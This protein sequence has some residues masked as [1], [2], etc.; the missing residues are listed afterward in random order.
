[1]NNIILSQNQTMS[2]LEMAE[3]TGKRHD[4]VKRTIEMLLTNTDKRKAVIAR[5]QIVILEKIN[6]L[7]LPSKTETYVFSGEQGK[8]DSII[9]V[10]QLS[11]EFTAKIVDRWQYLEN[12]EIGKQLKKATRQET[13]IEYKPMTNAIQL[14]HE[15]P[16][17]YHFS[18]EADMINRIILGTTSSKF[19]KE[20]DIGENEAIRDYMTTRQLDAFLSLQRA[21]TVYI[22]DG[23]EYQERKEKLTALFNRKHKDILIEEV[24]LINA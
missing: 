8:R 24:H 22:E 10:A 9:V 7:G 16:K 15:Q 12:K 5:P 17:P 20:N 19:R 14:A 11:P 3:L 23:I 18:N 21:N 13:K 2:S 6:N 1:M 4:S